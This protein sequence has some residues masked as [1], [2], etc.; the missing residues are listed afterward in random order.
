MRL[1]SRSYLLAWSAM[2]FW[3][4]SS[5]G[6]LFFFASESSF[7]CFVF[8]EVFLL[9][10]KSIKNGVAGLYNHYYDFTWVYLCYI[11]TP[12]C[13]IL[14]QK[15]GVVFPL[16]SLFFFSQALHVLLE[17]V[18]ISYAFTPSTL[19]K[20][21]E[22]TKPLP[23]C[24]SNTTLSIFYPLRAILRPSNS[25]I[26]WFLPSWSTTSYSFKYSYQS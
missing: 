14:T 19:H 5:F 1:H 6:I 7:I 12:S 21:S 2:P 11:R 13:C 26:V 18:L 17:S 10:N 23:F 9:E 20:P 4:G 16:P 24:M 8:E 15:L 22:K 25:N 3:S